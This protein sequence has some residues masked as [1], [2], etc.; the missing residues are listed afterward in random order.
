[1]FPSNWHNL[2]VHPSYAC[3]ATNITHTS[4]TRVSRAHDRWDFSERGRFFNR[5]IFLRR[6]GFD[7]R[8]TRV[9][10][11]TYTRR[12]RARVHASYRSPPVLSLGSLQPGGR[13]EKGCAGGGRGEVH[14]VVFHSH[15]RNVLP[16]ALVAPRNKSS[17]TVTMGGAQGGYRCRRGAPGGY[18]GAVHPSVQP[19][20]K[21]VRRGIWLCNSRNLF[22]L[23]FSRSHLGPLVQES[24]PEDL[25]GK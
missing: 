7:A 4:I 20:G 23:P 13:I 18:R 2:T 11:H 14:T 9:H 21:P 22:F 16:C 24:S 8:S 5:A 1:M 6:G 17:V 3:R 25:A 12:V 10:A 19:S 15:Y